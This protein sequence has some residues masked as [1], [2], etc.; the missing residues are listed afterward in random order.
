VGTDAE[1]PN[2]AT[3]SIRR[4]RHREWDLLVRAPEVVGQV[5]IVVRWRR[6]LGSRWGQSSR[7]HPAGGR[8]SLPCPTKAPRSFTL[9]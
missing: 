6:S 1:G 3:L 7:A 4:R 5:L 2:A 8:M 9:R